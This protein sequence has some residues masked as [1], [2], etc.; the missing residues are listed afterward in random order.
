MTR[1]ISKKSPAAQSQCQ[2]VVRELNA[3]H[4]RTESAIEGMVPPSDSMMEDHAVN[5]TS[6]T[7]PLL[8]ST[9]GFSEAQLE[10]RL[11]ATIYRAD[12]ARRL[13]VQDR[14]DILQI[15][16]LRLIE[17][18]E[19]ILNARNP[20]GRLARVVRGR[21]SDY[22]KQ[23]KIRVEVEFPNSLMAMDRV[24][25]LRLGKA[26]KPTRKSY[27]T[28]SHW[29][30]RLTLTQLGRLKRDGQPCEIV[31]GLT[32]PEFEDISD[33]ELPVESYGLKFMAVREAWRD[34]RA[35]DP[36]GAQILAY[37][38]FYEK[39]RTQ[40]A[41]LVGVRRGECDRLF[42]R[43]RRKFAKLYPELAHVLWEGESWRR[44]PV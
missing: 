43:A 41:H 26:M 23:I 10:Q 18:P 44:K 24:A 36:L 17:K 6:E 19:E 9:L 39:N 3:K 11:L 42:E 15:V 37:R 25:L 12:Q 20:P 30:G 33:K 40:T 5:T 38:V 8:L 21:V 27:S 4:G 31:H 22:P 2:L 34:F 13:T 14:E 7:W 32:V 1:D 29:T 35:R 28:G 16:Y